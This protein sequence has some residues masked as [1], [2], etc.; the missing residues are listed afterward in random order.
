[1]PGPASETGLGSGDVE[2]FLQEL[3]PLL[4]P[5]E[6]APGVGRPR[7]LPALC[8][9][10]GVLVCC[11]RE[12]ALRQRA[13]WRLLSFHGLWHYPRFALSDEAIRRRLQR[14]TAGTAPTPLERWFVAVGAVLRPRLAPAAD[15]TL[16][17]FASA[18][19]ALDESTLEPL[20]RR[21]PALK[22]GGAERLPGKLTAVFDLRRQ[23]W[24]HVQLSDQPHQNEKRAAWPLLAQLPAGCLLVVDLGYWS[25]AW[26]DALIAAGHH[27]LSRVRAGTSY[28]ILHTFYQQGD[29]LDCLVFLGKHRSDRM[30]H[31]LRLVQFRQ[32]GTLYRYVTSQTDPRLLPL[33]EVVRVYRRRWDLE[34]AFDLVKRHL[35]LHFCWSCS[36]AVLQA[37]VWAV[38]TISLILQAVRLEV[39]YQAGVT[40]DDVSLPLLIAVLPRLLAD[41]VEPLPRLVSAGRRA[42]IIRP[43]RRQVLSVPAVPAYQYTLPPPTV[44]REQVPRY[45]HRRC[46]PPQDGHAT[47]YA[48]A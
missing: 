25:Y 26:F 48:P 21:L 7:L 18:V 39:A 29:T 35:G 9:W 44:L 10:A 2:A 17:P 28:R 31:A 38:L 19:L 23:L 47:A 32:G 22:A 6:A 4:E 12:G 5:L 11:L 24:H 30:Q 14:E 40:P 15:A 34:L 16:A 13:V 27:L 36:V 8:L 46:S 20:A 37:Q 3:I 43:A 42:E 33:A 1:M 45:A 41:G